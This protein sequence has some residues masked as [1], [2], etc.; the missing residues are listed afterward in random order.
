MPFSARLSNC[1]KLLIVLTALSLGACMSSDPM[2]RAD[3]PQARQA[4]QLASEGDLD[5]AARQFL[6]LA[7]GSSGSASAHYRL[8]A[9]EVLRENG[10]LDGAARAISEIRR[11]RLDADE[12][13]RLDLIDA[14]VS[15]ERGDAER[16]SLLLATNEDSIPDRLR[17]RYSELRART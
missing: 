8:R 12:S 13:F 2:T 6:A 17:L 10:D 5:A 4:E 1:L 7:E 3:S 9:A 11:N 16:A 14:E 15:L